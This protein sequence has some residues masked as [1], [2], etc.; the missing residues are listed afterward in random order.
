MGVLDQLVGALSGGQV[1]S[2]GRAALDLLDSPQVGGIQGLADRLGRM[3]LGNV[4]GS[5]VS[6]GAN[7]PISGEQLKD[8]LGPDTISALAQK[9][10]IS[11]AQAQQALSQLLPGLIDKLTPN[12]QIARGQDLTQV[13]MNA[14]KSM[15]G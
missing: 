10:G 3:G 12:G 11:S 7:L 2:L 9:A 15:L 4:F 13:G 6:T 8:A 1:S 14:L 5:W